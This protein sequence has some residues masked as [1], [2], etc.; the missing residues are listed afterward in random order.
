MSTISIGSEYGSLPISFDPA[1]YKTAANAAK[2]MY[3]ALCE[4]ARELGYDAEREVWIKTPEESEAHGTGRC[5]HVCWESGPYEWA[6][7]ASHGAAN[8]FFYSEP[9]WSFSLCFYSN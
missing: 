6:V 5:W 7:E 3:R 8:R 4:L 1:K 9:H 2:G